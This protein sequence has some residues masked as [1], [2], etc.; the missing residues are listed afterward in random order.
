[1]VKREFRIYG[2]SCMQPGCSVFLEVMAWN[3]CFR[4]KPFE[5]GTVNLRAFNLV[6]CLETNMVNVSTMTRGIIWDDK[7][8]TFVSRAL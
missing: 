2:K 6:S 4:K 8:N 7:R 1:M 3:F 5:M